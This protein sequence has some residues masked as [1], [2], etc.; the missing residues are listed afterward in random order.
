MEEKAT[1]LSIAQK[2]T[3]L[4]QKIL[5]LQKVHYASGTSIKISQQMI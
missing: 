3:N 2:F 4:K 5:K 1:H